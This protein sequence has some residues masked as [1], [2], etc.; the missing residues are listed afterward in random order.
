MGLDMAMYTWR[1][2]TRYG[3]KLGD[4]DSDCWLLEVVQATVEDVNTWN[5]HDDCFALLLQNP[6]GL[7]RYL[8]KRTAFYLRAS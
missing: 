5:R 7:K 6:K 2:S 1:K 4:R 3:Q 8:E